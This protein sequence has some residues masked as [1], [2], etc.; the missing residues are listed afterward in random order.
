MSKVRI[1]NAD[2]IHGAVGDALDSLGAF[3]Y[4]G[5]GR[6]VF[7]KPNLT[8]PT[9]RPGVTTS[10]RLLRAVLSNLADSGSR[11]FVGESDGGYGAWSADTAFDGHGLRAICSTFGATLVNLSQSASRKV[12]LAILGEMYRLALPEILLD[13]TD[14]FITL[15]VPKMH[16]MVTYSGAV[17]N[18]WGCIPDPMRIKLHPHFARLIWAVNER[19][20]PRL[21]I[22][23]CEYML[24]RNGPMSGDPVYMNRIVV[25][26]DIL[27]FDVA[28][29]ERTMRLNPATVAY[30]GLGR[31]LGHSWHADTVEDRSTGPPHQFELHR[32]L[33]NRL[34]AAAFQRQWA[35]NLV[36]DSRPGRLAHRVLYAFTGNPVARERERVLTM[37]QIADSE[38]EHPEDCGQR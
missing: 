38:R 4:L 30:L 25:A 1:D 13:E 36:W 16:S 24:D 3:E 33:R 26:D 19:L 6:R 23:D 10:P 8:Y 37:T 32:T 35:V 22:G 5:K 18:Q 29:L 15:P 14:V 27:A 31:Q 28:V 21:A 11:V 34:A 9:H 17:K 12:G 7:L 2:D 20:A